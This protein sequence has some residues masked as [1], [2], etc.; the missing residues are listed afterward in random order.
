MPEANFFRSPGTFGGQGGI[1]GTSS[2]A[3][4]SENGNPEDSDVSIARLL[5]RLVEQAPLLLAS[6]G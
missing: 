2:T 4:Y 6:K 1:P 3:F 5:L